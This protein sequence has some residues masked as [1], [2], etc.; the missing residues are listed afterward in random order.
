MLIL[1]IDDR[2]ES[3][4]RSVDH[5]SSVVSERR[6]SSTVFPDPADY[7]SL[8]WYEKTLQRTERHLARLSEIRDQH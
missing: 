7:P 5:Y 3:V 2:V 6:S 4:R 8:D 1:N